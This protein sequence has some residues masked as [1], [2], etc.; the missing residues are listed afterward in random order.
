MP[1]LSDSDMK[2]L[3]ERASRGDDAAIS[4]L[5]E[6]HFERISRYVA[7]RVPDSEVEDITAGVFVRMLEGLPDFE[8]TGAP[9]EAWLYRIAQAR[10]ADFYRK[11]NRQREEDIPEHLQAEGQLPEEKLLQAYEFAS[12]RKALNQ[13]SDNERDLLLLRFVERKSHRD[14]AEILDKSEAATRTMQHR[15][16]T[17]LADLLEADGKERHYL[18][19]SRP[20]DAPDS[21]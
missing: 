12:V 14:V 11:R 4:R 2:D 16:L 1:S 13:L 8:Y 20:P 17:K 3:I 19:G 6:M 9:F 7:Y 15:A 21:D 5:Y 10:V 18:R